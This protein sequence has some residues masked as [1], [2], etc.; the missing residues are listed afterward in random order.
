VNQS[1]T[2]LSSAY[3]ALPVTAVTP[4]ARLPLVQVNNFGVTGGLQIANAGTA[5][6][7]ATITF[8]DNTP[9]TSPDDPLERCRVVPSPVTET[10]T[11]LGTRTI[12]LRADDP[13]FHQKRAGTGPDERCSYVS[14]VEV[15]SNGGKVA[16]LANQ[17]SPSGSDKLSTYIGS[18][19]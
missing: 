4:T 10:L 9:R 15:T 13:A 19:G 7:T 12:L 16:V 17:I 6:V 3:E 11:P 8:L 2:G 14:S 5:D 1:G 18:P